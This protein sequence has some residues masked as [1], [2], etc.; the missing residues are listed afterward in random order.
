ME[1]YENYKEARHR[2]LYLKSG[3]GRD[4]L[5]AKLERCQSG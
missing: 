5:K 4:W 1:E 3:T 2:E